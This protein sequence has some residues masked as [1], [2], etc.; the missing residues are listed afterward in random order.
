MKFSVI[1]PVYNTA[2]YLKECIDS[3]LNQ[4]FL[5]YEIILVDDGSNDSSGLLCDEYATLHGFIKVI[6][7][8]N[9][10]Q[11][12]ARNAGLRVSKGVYIV[13]IDSDDFITDKDFLAKLASRTAGGSDIIAYKYQKFYDKT[14]ILGNCGFTFRGIDQTAPLGTIIKELVKRNA[15]YCS[16]W[17]KSI[18]RDILIRHGI[19]FDETS[20][21]EDMDWYFSVVQVISTMEFLDEPFIAYRQRENSV[22][23]VT[24]LKTVRDFISF[25]D[26]WVPMIDTL[27]NAAMRDA[28]RAAI[29]KFYV[30]LML[31]YVHCSDKRKKACLAGVRQYS[32]LLQ[33]DMNPRTKK[34]NLLNKIA[35]FRL[36]MAIL[37]IMVRAR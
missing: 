4:T 34:I 11:S 14:K 27:G 26:K 37:W 17:S 24:S 16:A 23:S 19:Y 25:F 12:T 31:S 6:H 33:Y 29:A 9:G 13:F 36:T 3:I 22:T 21:C 20:R 15:F 28:L 32:T 7:K 30:N 18:R 10:G 8:P 2:A 5:D 1:I 35:G